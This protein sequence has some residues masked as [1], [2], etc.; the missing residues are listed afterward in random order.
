LATTS[1]ESLR[2]VVRTHIGPLTQSTLAKEKSTGL[3][4]AVDDVRVAG[5]NTAEQ[6]PAAGCGLHTVLAGNIVLHNERDTVERSTDLA[7]G[8]LLVQLLGDGECIGVELQ[9]RARGS[10]SA[11]LQ[12]P[13]SMG[14]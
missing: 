13:T 11:Q 8:A 14:L 2:V 6:S 12:P 10:L 3:A 5:H 4:H 7:M 1:S 9:N